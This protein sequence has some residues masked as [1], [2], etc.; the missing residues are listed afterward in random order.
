MK[1][2]YEE[3]FLGKY[4]SSDFGSFYREYESCIRE[5]NNAPNEFKKILKKDIK[6]NVKIDDIFQ[7]RDQ[8]EN[9]RK[10]FRKN[11]K[12]NDYVTDYWLSKV[13]KKSTIISL[14]NNIEFNELTIEQAFDI[15]SVNF[16][17]ASFLEMPSL[18]LKHGIILVYEKSIP[19]LNVDGVVYKNSN[20]NPVIALSIRHNRLD[21][22][23]FTLA[24]EISHII[25]HY[26]QLDTIIIDDFDKLDEEHIEYEANRLAAD[27][28]IP[29]TTWRSSP[30]KSS[31]KSYDVI[32]YAT[33][34]NV[35]P[36]IIAGRIRR[37]TKNY[38]IL[39]DIIF[40]TDLRKELF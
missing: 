11:S 29:R 15:L 36:A 1:D 4:S 31:S 33:E 38:K 34:I 20:G 21:N 9:H 22:F 30:V 18:L 2:D 32:N 17:T 5:L 10:F 27:L 23:W 3:I 13:N 39:T 40:K 35:H 7:N 8:L 16:T 28:L 25:L 14:S 6:N 24:H 19:G 37:E 26:N 12:A